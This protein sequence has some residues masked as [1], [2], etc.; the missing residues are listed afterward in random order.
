MLTMKMN[1]CGIY[2]RYVKNKEQSTEY[3]FSCM[4]VNVEQTSPR[5]LEAKE[6][7]F[8]RKRFK[9]PS[10]D[11]ANNEEFLVKME[12]NDTCTLISLGYIIKEDSLENVILA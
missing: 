7:R 11:N 5:R 2:I 3:H 10:N 1:L 8:Y 4:A 12:K 9:I 6:M